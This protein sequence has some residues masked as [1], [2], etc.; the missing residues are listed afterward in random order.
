[1]R[2]YFYFFLIMVSL[3]GCRLNYSVT[4]F[5]EATET[6]DEIAILPFEVIIDNRS[7]ERLSSSETRVI[8][9]HESE[10]FQKILYDK[11]ER[12][13]KQGKRPF[14]VKIQHPNKTLKI[15]KENNIDIRDSW[16]KDPVELAELLAVDAVICVKVEKLKYFSDAKSFGMDVGVVILNALTIFLGVNAALGAE[17][18]NKEIFSVYE[19]VDGKEGF[20]LWSTN[21][22][23]FGGWH[24]NFDNVVS[25]IQRHSSRNFP[26]RV[27]EPLLKKKKKRKKRRR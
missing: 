17:S 26:Y 25:R 5:E 10:I 15:L 13:T 23:S 12:S 21:Y 9:E 3:S 8:E 22:N 16:F 7:N 27:E 24:L 14:K 1:M 18:R 4:D 2:A 11:L 6:H 20:V 19:L